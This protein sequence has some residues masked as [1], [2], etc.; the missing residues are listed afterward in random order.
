MKVK[1]LILFNDLKAQKLRREGEIFDV[2]SKRAGEL[3]A[4]PHGVLIE[5][6][7]KPPKGG[8]GDAGGY[9]ER[10]KNKK[11]KS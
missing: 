7:E 9:K 10:P 2:S 8:E 6:I 1:A 11:R 5:V 4:G 3:N